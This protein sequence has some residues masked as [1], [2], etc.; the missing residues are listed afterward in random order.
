M[1][2]SVPSRSHRLIR[3]VTL[4]LACAAATLHAQSAATGPQNNN[5]RIAS[6]NFGTNGSNPEGTRNPKERILQGKVQDPNGKPIKGAIVYLKDKHNDSMKSIVV[7]DEG[8]YRFAQL[9]LN[10]DYE[11]W[12]QL[13]KKKGVLK[14]IS[15]FDD[16]ADIM[17]NLKIE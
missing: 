9:L 13:D 11:I 4:G 5:K 2:N 16:R 12:A 7:D 3:L 15:S 1:L 14:Q 10:K 6:I 17:L 8:A